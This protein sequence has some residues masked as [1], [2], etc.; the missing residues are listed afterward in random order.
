MF[1]L[2]SRSLFVPLFVFVN[3]P[4]VSLADDDPPK[5]DSSLHFI[6]DSETIFVNIDNDPLVA[7][8][9]PIFAVIDREFGG[10]AKPRTVVFE[11]RL[12]TD[13]PADVSVSGR[14]ALTEGQT[15]AVRAS[16]DVAKSPRTRVVDG[17]FRIVAKVQGGTPDD[18]G[19]LVPP[20]PTLGDRKLARFQPLNGSQKLAA[21]QR[22]ARTEAIPLIAE[23]AAHRDHPRDAAVRNFA[24][25]LRTVPRDGPVDVA[26]LTDKNRDFWRAMMTAPRGDPLL[27]AAQVVLHVANGEI[28]WAKRIADVIDLFDGRQSGSSSVLADFR[29]MTD[30]FYQEQADRIRKGIA[31][32]DQK[33]FDAA[34]GIYDAVLKDDPKSSWALYERFH[35]MQMKGL[36]AKDPLD[37]VMEGWPKVRKAILDVDPMFATMAVAD[38]PNAAYDLLLRKETEELFREGQSPGHSA[39]RYAEIVLELGQPGFAAM[40]YWNIARHMRPSD[41]GDRKLT[42]DMYYCLELL[43]LKDLKN[44]VLA[45]PAAVFQRIDAERAKRKQESPAFRALAEPKEAESVKKTPDR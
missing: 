6:A 3:G 41:Y 42:E 44:G 34:I 28:R 10:E 27:P 1:R 20:L 33:Q 11:A 12:H 29:W 36:T 37:R 25:A 13:R 22:W 16:A 18:S 43:G 26:A 32:S 15:R 9:Q 5:V 19:P 7:W 45:N 8:V 21:L 39:V 24:K 23:F 40:L 14:P 17:T 31:L 30:V 38:S 2:V 4:A 35:T